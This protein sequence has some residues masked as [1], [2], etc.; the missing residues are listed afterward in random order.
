MLLGQMEK[1]EYWPSFFLTLN[2]EG[3]DTY[4]SFLYRAGYFLKQRF[5]RPGSPLA[6]H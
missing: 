3:L 2:G 4:W 1:S 5:N 6:I